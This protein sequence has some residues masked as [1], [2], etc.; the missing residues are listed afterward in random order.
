MS[1]VLFY[2]N[3]SS[4]EK[5]CEKVK[6]FLYHFV[7]NS[8]KVKVCQVPGDVHDK[9]SA[10]FVDSPEPML[11]N[12]LNMVIRNYDWKSNGIEGFEESNV[13]NLE[14][15]PDE[16]A[17]PVAEFYKL[18]PGVKPEC[19]KP[20]TFVYFSCKTG[21]EAD[22]IAAT[23]RHYLEKSFENCLSIK[24]TISQSDKSK[25]YLR[26][27]A[28]KKYLLSDGYMLGL[29][30]FMTTFDWQSY[31]IEKPEMHEGKSCEDDVEIKLFG[32]VSVD[33]NPENIFDLD[34]RVREDIENQERLKHKG[35]NPSKFDNVKPPADFCRVTAE[36]SL[37]FALQAEEVSIS[38]NNMYEIL[39]NAKEIYD[40]LLGASSHFIEGKSLK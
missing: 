24:K 18:N 38:S 28:D 19:E 4:I 17:D 12:Y 8:H 16:S 31:G 37:K 35:I 26:A 29:I 14:D 9:K 7:L 2:F 22:L 36:L 23:A 1:R 3:K 11:V 6:G 39:G 13:V 40:F 15:K 30:E 20:K 27:F 21:A 10:I 25:T 5:A 32:L 33:S 34:K